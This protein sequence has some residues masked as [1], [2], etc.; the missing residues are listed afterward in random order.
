MTEANTIDP[1]TAKR[2][3]GEIE[4]CFEELA[5]LQGSYMNACAGVRTR[6]KDWKDAANEAGLP[7]KA[8]NIEL[9]R[10]EL[11]R[12]L[13]AVTDDIDEDVVDLA[14]QI[15]EALGGMA[16]LPLG[17]AAVDAADKGKK[18]AKPRK[19]KKADSET[20]ASG[21]DAL[22]SLINDDVPEGDVRPRH[23]REAEEARV[24]ENTANLAGMKTL[25]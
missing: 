17:Q 20:A 13:E 2:F 22:N 21:S 14:D 25:N 4:K 3:V 6:I 8:L 15:R 10:R 16:D 18:P 24:A 7:R 23:L 19:G 1:T 12:K 9:K 5:S 11:Q